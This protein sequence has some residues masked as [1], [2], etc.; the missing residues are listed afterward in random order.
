MLSASL[1]DVVL[2][3]YF[4]QRTVVF[5]GCLVILCQLQLFSTGLLSTCYIGSSVL[6]WKCK[7][8]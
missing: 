6:D 8:L 7:I 2:E 1:Y 4:C 5:V 3:I